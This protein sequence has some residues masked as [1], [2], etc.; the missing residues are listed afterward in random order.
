VAPRSQDAIDTY[1]PIF[2]AR[3]AMGRS[4]GVE[5]VFT[6]VDDFVDRSSA[7][8]GSP[9]QVIDKVQRYH[10]RLGHS[11]ISFGT[12]ADGLTVRQ[13]RDSLELFQ[14]SVAP[15]LRRRIADPPWP[16]SIAS[17]TSPAT[18]PATSAA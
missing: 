5:P 9:E 2:E 6:S 8:I 3:A 10:D 15:E 11:V 13:H 12:D 4:F 17:T 14:H 16:A 1:R 7:L 18:T